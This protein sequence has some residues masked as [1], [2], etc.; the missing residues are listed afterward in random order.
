[1]RYTRNS[2]AVAGTAGGLSRH[3]AWGSSGKTSQS[4]SG[5]AA[6]LGSG[7]LAPE[8]HRERLPWRGKGPGVSPEA[9]Q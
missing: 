5:G 1:M 9:P 6:G 8:H 2:T 3:R 7:S 4:S